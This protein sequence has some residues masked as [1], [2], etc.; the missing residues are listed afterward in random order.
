MEASETIK[1]FCG[2][3]GIAYEP[4]KY[5]TCTF[6]ADGLCVA[7]TDVREIDSIGLVGDLGEP[8][9]ERLENLY[10]MML[11]ANHLLGGTGGATLSLNPDNGRFALCQFFQC[12]TTDAD[13]LY[14]E[15]ERFVCTLETWTKVIGDFRDV[16]P[17]VP[18]AGEDASD[19]LP[20][21]GFI[22]V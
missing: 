20:K 15:I 16:L 1:A 19:G 7:V 10:K 4:D 22:S 5:G 21:S 17:S 12:R 9:P 13:V 6:K 2:K 8:P 11:E 3:V 14:S 18:K